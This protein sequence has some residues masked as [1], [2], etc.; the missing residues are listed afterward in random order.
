MDTKYWQKRPIEALVVL[1]MDARWWAQQC[2]GKRVMADHSHDCRHAW[3]M[4]MGQATDLESEV[5][6]HVAVESHDVVGEEPPPLDAGLV[7]VNHHLPI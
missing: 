3:C 2:A 7:C 1:D 4:R 5:G 6:N